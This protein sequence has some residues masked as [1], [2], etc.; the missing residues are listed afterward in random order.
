[1]INH[2]PTETDPKDPGHS[3]TRIFR[4]DGHTNPIQ[5][6]AKSRAFHMRQPK[7]PRV[8]KETGPR[9]PRLKNLTW[10]YYLDGVPMMMEEAAFLIGLSYKTLQKRFKKDLL[11]ITYMGRTV[12][13]VKRKKRVFTKNGKKCPPSTVKYAFKKGLPQIEEEIRLAGGQVKIGKHIFSF[14]FEDKDVRA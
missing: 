13:R 5:C 11:E 1:M 8:R 2:W 12:S 4:L 10:Q 6:G 7:E 14:T 3:Y 9:E